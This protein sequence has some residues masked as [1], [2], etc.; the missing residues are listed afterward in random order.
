MVMDE[1]GVNYDIPECDFRGLCEPPVRNDDILSKCDVVDGRVV[2]IDC[3]ISCHGP[4]FGPTCY[5]RDTNVFEMRTSTHVHTGTSGGSEMDQSIITTPEP[6][7]LTNVLSLSDKDIHVS[8]DGMKSM[9]KDAAGM[10]T[11][12]EAVL[13]DL[14][15]LTSAAESYIT[16][17][18]PK[19]RSEGLTCQECEKTLARNS[20]MATASIIWS[21]LTCPFLIFL[22]V[23]A[24]TTS[25]GVGG[26]CNVC[27][28]RH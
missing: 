19:P 25:P 15:Q 14:E 10:L 5:R 16:K 27:I 8:L 24:K 2:N 4:C 18:K 17:T 28:P 11:R 20:F 1:Q 21:A 26:N 22:A 12:G 3:P 9:S 6:R 7:V 13:K 23:R